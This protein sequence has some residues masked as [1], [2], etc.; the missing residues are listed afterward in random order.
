[1]Y[2]ILAGTWTNIFVLTVVYFSSFIVVLEKMS[3][4]IHFEASFGEM[5]LKFDMPYPMPHFHRYLLSVFFFLRISIQVAPFFFSPS[6]LRLSPAAQCLFPGSSTKQPLYSSSLNTVPS[7]PA[8][9]FHLQPIEFLPLVYLYSAGADHWLSKERALT[10]SVPSARDGSWD[11]TVN[12]FLFGRKNKWLYFWEITTGKVS[13]A[14]LLSIPPQMKD[15][16]IR[17]ER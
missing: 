12:A 1:M 10:P 14:K 11:I 4:K 8:T 13:I 15:E 5:R 3:T 9:P 16:N 17:W 6:N 7:C 2:L